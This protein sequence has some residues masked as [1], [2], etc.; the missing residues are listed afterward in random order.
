M[1]KAKVGV[2]L[3]A[4]SALVKVITPRRLLSKV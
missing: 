3:K 4:L 1:V 2:A